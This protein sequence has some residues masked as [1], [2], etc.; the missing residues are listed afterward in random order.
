MPCRF[1]NLDELTF[2]SNHFQTTTALINYDEE[3]AWINDSRF[4]W[5]E[6]AARREDN[7]LMNLGDEGDQQM[8]NRDG[9]LIGDGL[10]GNGEHQDN[11]EGFEID[12][13]QSGE[14]AEANEEGEEEEE[15]EGM[16]DEEN[17]EGDMDAI[18]AGAED[19]GEEGGEGEEEEGGVQE[20][21]ENE[22]Q[23]GAV[24]APR[25][26]TETIRSGILAAE[27]RKDAVL[28]KAS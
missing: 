25:E 20:V 4:S 13:H 9:D 6:D 12:H 10:I 21:M 17:E 3:A 8:T 14:G 5:K 15:E 19:L 1:K 18:D 24:T 7:H 27:A 23:G 2:R 22:G 16:S 26:L 11:N 28:E